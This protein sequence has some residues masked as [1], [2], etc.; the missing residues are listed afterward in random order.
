MDFVKPPDRYQTIV[1]FYGNTRPRLA[2]SRLLDK[3][4]HS[5]QSKGIQ[6]LLKSPHEN[7]VTAMQN[8]LYN[9]APRGWGR[10]SYR[11]AEIIQLGRI[12]IYI[13]DDYEW[14]PYQNS[15]ISFHQMNYGFSV[16]GF[17]PG[18]VEDL[19]LVLQRLK[20]DP[21]GNKVMLDNVL[22]VR[23]YYTYAGVIEQ[24][25]LFIQD[26]LGPR[27]GY[28]TCSALPPNAKSH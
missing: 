2:R 15:N 12:P 21:K 3:V 7:W 24:I 27:G 14:L 23:R 28:L 4:Q 20:D 8:T 26:P 1:G 17:N 6:T 22:A 18:K 16:N 10:T 9:L 19:A 13:Y 5:F 25:A 11:L